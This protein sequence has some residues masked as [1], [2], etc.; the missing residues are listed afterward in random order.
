MPYVDLQTK[1]ETERQEIVS[2][3]ER[4]HQILKEEEQRLLAELDEMEKV[5]QEA[6]DESVAK[7]AEEI[8]YYDERIAE[9]KEVCQKTP[10][11]ILMVRE[12]TF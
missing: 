11:E 2:H 3:F 1:T 5:I 10:V 9:R 12:V 8:S 4:R 6:K 7:L